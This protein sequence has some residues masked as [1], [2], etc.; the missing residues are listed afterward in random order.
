[1]DGLN[2]VLLFLHFLGL[3]LG[4]SAPFAYMATSGLLSRAAPTEKAVLGRLPPLMSHL[5]RTG[6]ALLWVTGLVLV[7]TRW[8]GFATLPW[9]FHVKLTAVVLFTISVEYSHRL[10]RML[11]KGDA[12]GV[13]RADAAGKIAVLFAVI[14]I[15][16]AVLTF[17]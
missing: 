8:N 9:Q 1:M 16:F 2:Q 13:A 6:L 14:A 7:Y 5:G 15:A 3:A 11:Q 12:A 4:L 10:G 17:N